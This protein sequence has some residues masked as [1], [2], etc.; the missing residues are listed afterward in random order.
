[1]IYKAANSPFKDPIRLKNIATMPDYK[2]WEMYAMHAPELAYVAMHV[3]SKP[4]GVGGVERSHKKLNSSVVTKHRNHLN[5][6]AQ[7]REVYVNMNAPTVAKVAH[8]SYE[9]PFPAAEAS[10][11]SDD[12]DA[13]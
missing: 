3:L 6:G 12:D 13:D 5:H 2:W 9:L 11:D 7:Q 8:P 1:M 4:I 10:S